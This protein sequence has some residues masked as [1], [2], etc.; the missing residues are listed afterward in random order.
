MAIITRYCVIV[1]CAGAL[2]ARTGRADGAVV[3]RGRVRHEQRVQPL[4]VARGVQAQR[5]RRRPA[6]RLAVARLR[7][8][9]AAAALR[10]RLAPPATADTNTNINSLYRPSYLV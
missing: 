9:A 6:Q 5:Q 1:V 8:L 10:L 2:V 7:G 3:E 4:Q